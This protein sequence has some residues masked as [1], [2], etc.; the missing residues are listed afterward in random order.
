MTSTATALAQRKSQAATTQLNVVVLVEAGK[1]V[2]QEEYNTY[3]TST[4]QALGLRPAEVRL[5]VITRARPELAPLE[6]FSEIGAVCRAAPRLVVQHPAKAWDRWL[7]ERGVPTLTWPI[8]VRD[9][10]TRQILVTARDSSWTLPSLLGN[11][12]GVVEQA[13]KVTI[14]GEG[15]APREDDGVTIGLGAFSAYTDPVPNFFL[16]RRAPFSCPANDPSDTA[17]GLRRDALLREKTPYIRFGMIHGAAITQASTPEEREA[18]KRAQEQREVFANTMMPRIVCQASLL[19]PPPV[20]EFKSMLWSP[21]NEITV[22]EGVATSPLVRL[23]IAVR[24]LTQAAVQ[25]RLHPHSSRRL[26]PQMAVELN[27]LEALNIKLDM[28]GETV[29]G[30]PLHIRYEGNDLRLGAGAAA[31]AEWL[32]L[33]RGAACATTRI[34]A[35]DEVTAAFKEKG[36]GVADDIPD[37]IPVVTLRPFPLVPI[38]E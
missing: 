37:D 32:A 34:T 28:E 13:S 21:Y 2:T 22:Q 30:K 7:V 6:G 24:A 12:K 36:I 20:N 31:L 3:R 29:A 35:G 8:N 26:T 14:L 38:P 33:E 23:G 16:S 11:V 25:V 18:A 17:V 4:A 5:E 1:Q 19:E 15:V 10:T 9:E 27:I